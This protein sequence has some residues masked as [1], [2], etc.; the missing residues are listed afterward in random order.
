MSKCVGDN[1]IVTVHYVLLELGQFEHLNFKSIVGKRGLRVRLR[2]LLLR[3]EILLRCY[4]LIHHGKTSFCSS[5]ILSR[6]G[7]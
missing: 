7:V 2:P 3:I 4:T 1:L 5:Y 6:E